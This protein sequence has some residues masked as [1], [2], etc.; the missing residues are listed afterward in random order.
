MI[1]HDSR[2]DHPPV[3]A[4][5]RS[6]TDAG[7]SRD[8]DVKLGQPCR[9][10][11]PLNGTPRG[12]CFG[13]VPTRL[14][15]ARS[16]GCSALEPRQV[17]GA[18]PGSWG[19]GGATSGERARRLKV[20]IL[21]GRRLAALRCLVRK[22]CGLRNVVRVGGDLGHRRS[23]PP[24]GREASRRRGVGPTRLGTK[25]ARGGRARHVVSRLAARAAKQ[26]TACVWRSP[27]VRLV[28]ER[29]CSHDNLYTSTE[30][31]TPPQG[32][33]QSMTATL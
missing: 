6:T 19:P 21:Q 15:S 5:M 32:A 2:P 13:L 23:I 17:L 18:V 29:R 3:R 27:Q 12:N 24:A 33:T 7:V 1:R 11:Q 20:L 28:A 25:P 26:L 16:C 9:P 4:A 8:A 22:R 30:P 14:T 10:D 31:V